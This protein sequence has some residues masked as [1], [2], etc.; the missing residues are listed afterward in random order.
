M[1]HV[2]AGGLVDCLIW[3]LFALGA[4]LNPV[5]IGRHFGNAFT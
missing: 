4:A 2:A 5:C 3:R 1:V